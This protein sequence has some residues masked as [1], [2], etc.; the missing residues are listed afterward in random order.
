[1][2][3]MTTKR[4]RQEE[5]DRNF[6]FFSKELSNLIIDHRDRYA[7]LRDGKITGIY[8]TFMDAQ[9]AATQLFDDE[10]YSIQKITEAIGDL[11]FYSHA[12]HLGAA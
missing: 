9:T 6:E 7:L 12:V 3:E 5:V 1:V 2:E 10:I 11:G 4:T 8:D